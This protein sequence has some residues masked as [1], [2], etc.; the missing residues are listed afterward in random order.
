M[1]IGGPFGARTARAQLAIARLV[2]RALEIDV[3]V[4]QQTGDDR[5]RL[6]EAA[7]AVI[8]GIAEGVVFRLV[9]AGAD[10]RG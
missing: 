5:H 1:M 4:A 2:V 6:L 9:P 10:A 8:E 3:T 7:D